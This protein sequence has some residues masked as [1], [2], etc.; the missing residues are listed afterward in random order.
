MNAH[1]DGQGLALRPEQQPPERRVVAQSLG[2]LPLKP[3]DSALFD[4]ANLGLESVQNEFD[5]S[6]CDVDAAN[7]DELSRQLDRIND[8]LRSVVERLPEPD[9]A[10]ERQVDRFAESRE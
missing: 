5:A 6:L 9:A 2:A 4:E 1:P 3:E 10:A 7:W 8:L